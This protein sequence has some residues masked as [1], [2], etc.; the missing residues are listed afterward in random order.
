MC[1]KSVSLINFQSWENQKI[2]FDPKF[3]A[4]IGN[5][6]SGKSAIERAIRWV[7]ENRP[8]G[9][10]FVSWFAKEGEKTSVKLQF[11]DAFVIRRKIK[12]KNFYITNEQTFEAFKTEVPE[13]VKNILNMQ[14]YNIQSQHKK[15]FLLQDSPGERAKI[16]NNAVGLNIIDD[17]FDYLNSRSLKINRTLKQCQENITSTKEKL[18]KYENLDE[19]E[20]L[21]NSLKK[22]SDVLKNGYGRITKCENLV[23]R[24]KEVKRNI[25]SEKKWLGIE[26]EYALQ[27]QKIA[28][29]DEIKGIK[30][31]VEATLKSLSDIAENKRYAKKK[32]QEYSE[33]Y[34]KI[35]SENKECPICSNPITKSVIK[36]IQESL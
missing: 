7:V 6:D 2:E 13:E 8:S 12:S 17:L 23:E 5:S 10:E 21:I 18:K 25:K 26:V 33:E 30:T 4:I 35:L 3:N 24:I 34:L 27:C 32:I 36:K 19:V 29:C 31:K 11:E 20:D 14:E 1:L 28:K 16:L 22:K 15:Y 9:D